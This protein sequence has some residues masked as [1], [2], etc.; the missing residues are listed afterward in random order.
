[1]SADRNATRI[2]RRYRQH[3]HAGRAAV[4]ALLCPVMEKQWLPGWDYRM[5]HSA[6]GRAELG[7]VFATDGGK[8]P[9]IWIVTRYDKP[10]RI[11]FARWQ[12]EGVVVHLEI[13]L[14]PD[15]ENAT[16]V[17]IAYTYTAID[18]E[19]DQALAQTTDEQWR[20]NLAFWES[21]MNAWLAGNPQW[22]ARLA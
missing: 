18:D 16:V 5:I 2:V 17:D 11:A 9:T 22:P 1:M 4:F 8:A 10:A 6:S 12:P 19:G 7:A 13:E 14:H 21:S 15:A 3:I 20:Q